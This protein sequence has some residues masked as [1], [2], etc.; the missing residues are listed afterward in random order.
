M[1]KNQFISLHP[2]RRAYMGCLPEALSCRSL[3]YD[4]IL[5]NILFDLSEISVTCYEAA[6]MEVNSK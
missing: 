4:D 3:S 2:L 5:S 1:S 6:E